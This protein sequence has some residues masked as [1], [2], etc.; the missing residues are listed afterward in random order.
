MHLTNYAI[1]KESKFFVQ[2]ENEEADDR[3]SKRSY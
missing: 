2:N 3:G 1:N